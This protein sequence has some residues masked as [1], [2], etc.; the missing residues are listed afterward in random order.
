MN[1][2]GD[3][4]TLKGFFV[5]KLRTQGHETRHFFLCD[6][7]FLTP[8]VRERR[9]GNPKIG[10]ELVKSIQL[11]IHVN[12]PKNPPKRADRRVTRFEVDLTTTTYRP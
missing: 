6:S 10:Q 2:P 8:S 5:A 11:C 1:R 4:G 12:P 9:I 3:P 7:N